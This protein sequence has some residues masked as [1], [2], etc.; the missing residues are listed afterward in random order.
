MSSTTTSSERQ[1]RSTTL[2]VEASTFE[3]VMTAASDSA[4]ARPPSARANHVNADERVT[5]NW[6]YLLISESDVD[7]ARGS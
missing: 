5:A 2:W 7:A 6:G 3:L 4:S 1:S